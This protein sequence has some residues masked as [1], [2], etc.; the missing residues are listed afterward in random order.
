MSRE[1][2]SGVVQKMKRMINSKLTQKGAIR[3]NP[4]PGS[5]P[6]NLVVVRLGMTYDENWRMEPFLINILE[7]IR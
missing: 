6:A 2:M 3:S 4:L 1:K 5:P 7:A